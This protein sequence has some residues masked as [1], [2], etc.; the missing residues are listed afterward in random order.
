MTDS[1]SN[2]SPP[3]HDKLDELQPTFRRLDDSQ[4]N[5]ITNRTTFD[6][7]IKI[8]G[9]NIQANSGVIIMNFDD[10]LGRARSDALGEFETALLPLSKYDCHEVRIVGDYDIG[11]SS[12]PRKFTAARDK[13]AITEVS[14][15]GLP[16]SPGDTIPGP[17]VTVA[18]DS[19]PNADS[20]LFNGETLLKTETANA[21]GKITFELSALEPGEYSITLKDSSDNESQAFKFILGEAAVT[22]ATLD[23]VTDLDGNEIPKNSTTSKTS[24]YVEG[25]GEKGQKVEIF[26]GTDSLGEADVDATT[27]RYKYE[28]GPLAPKAYNLTAVAKWENGGTSDPYPF[29]VAAIKLATLDKVT[30]L[31][32]NEIPKNS[33]TS[34]TSLYV[35]GEGEKGQK[36][37]IFNGTDSLGEADVDATT[38]RYKYEIGPLAPKAYNLTAVA[39]W[40]NG[41]TSDPYPF[42]VAA[43]K[44]ATLDKVTDLDGNEIPKNSTTSKTSLYVEGEGEKGQKVEIFNSTDSLGEADVDATTGRYKYEIGPLV[45]KAYNLT[46]VAKWPSGGT[47]DPYPFT[48]EATVVA[49]TETRIYDADGNVIPDGGDIAK[50]W[51]IARGNYLPDSKVQIKLNGVIQQKQEDTNAEGQWVFFF[52]PLTVGTIYKISAL[53]P[54][55]KAESNEWSV[56][57]IPPV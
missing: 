6:R 45:P 27:G 33:T 39:K 48:V 13:P 20:R 53:T 21:C 42:T 51:L 32:G 14:S 2:I 25:E 18:C 30:D 26:N 43:I 38:G 36:V 1:P 12:L 40:E 3:S 57:A 52:S 41:G 37:E 5:P 50:N 10:E 7:Q 11:P 4:G 15:N 34:K 35:E 46:A 55:G 19:L 24:L 22:P 29:T 9:N 56:K 8:T 17:D 28:I 23:K 16:V 47:S 49:P 31:D 44:L 54:D